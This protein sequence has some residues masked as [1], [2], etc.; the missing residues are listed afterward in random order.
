MSIDEGTKLGLTLIAASMAQSRSLQDELDVSRAAHAYRT[1]WKDCVIFVQE[2]L[3][4]HDPALTTRQRYALDM[5]L[6]FKKP[7]IP[8]GENFFNYRNTSWINWDGIN[9]H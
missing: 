5:A 7:I 3:D 9:S 2:W 4:I 1:G 8:T 6:E